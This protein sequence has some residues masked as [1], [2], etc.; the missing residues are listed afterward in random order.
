MHKCSNNFEI[1]TIHFDNTSL[2][3]HVSDNS[4]AVEKVR[5]VDTLTLYFSM[6]EY[7][8][9]PVGAWTFFEGKRYELLDPKNFKKNNTR[10][11]EY[12]LVLEDDAGRLK[13]YKYR[14][15]N[16]R[17]LKFDLT[18][19]P[20]EHIEMLVWNLNQRDPGWTVGVCLDAVEKVVAYNHTSCWDALEQIA[21]AFDTEWEIVDK[22]ISLHK[23]EYYKDNPLPLS[24]GKGNGFKP[25]VGRSNYDKNSPVEILYPQGSDRNINSATYGSTELLLPKNQ[26]LG[27][28]GTT[29]YYNTGSVP[30]GKEVKWY[31]TDADGFSVL[32]K[33]KALTTGAEQSLD[34]SHIYPS[35]VGAISEVI[36]V[37]KDTNLYDFVDSSIPADLD[38]VQY[39]LAGQ[40]LTVIFQEGMLSGKE[41][42]VKYIH[43]DRRFEIVPQDLDGR[44][45]PDEVYKPF[46][47]QKYAVF[48]MMMPE[49]YICNNSSHT[50]AS[51]DMFRECV[52][53]FY[54][55]EDPRFS[56]TGELDSIWAK[57]D[58]EN[59]G[60]RI[61]KGGFIRFSDD[62]FQ[63]EG[64]DIRIVTVTRPANTPRKPKIDLSNVTVSGSIVGELNQIQ[65]NEVLA[66]SGA[67]KA[68][69]YA[70]RRFRDAQ[71]T[72]S[73]L[74]DALLDNFT[75]SINPIAVQTMAMLV[76]DESLQF[77]FVNS[78]TNPV[79]VTHRVVFNASTKQLTVPAGIIQH[80]T[81]GID[82][83]SSTHK[84]EEYRFW[85]LPLFP[86]P[87]L[88]DEKKYYVYA[89]VSR[90]NTTGEF[91]LS[92]T[93]IALESDANYYHL[94]LGILNSA[95]DGIRTDFVP[96]YGFTEILPGQIITDL[97]R[98]GDGKTYFDLARS[99]IGGN[100]KF[101]ATDG[102]S[103]DV[104]N[105]DKETSDFINT[106]FPQTIDDID[107]QIDGKVETWF[108]TT[109]PSRNWSNTDLSKRTGDMWYNAAAKSL[110]RYCKLDIT[111]PDNYFEQHFYSYTPT[112]ANT[113][114]ASWTT[115][116]LKGNHAGDLFYYR[117]T[118][119]VWQWEA[120]DEGVYSWVE[121]EGEKLA[122]AVI[123]GAD[124]I[125]L[126]KTT[127]KVFCATPFPPYEVGNLWIKSDS[128]VSRCI[129]AR[130][131]GS[132][133]ASHWSAL[134]TN[135]REAAL[136]VFAFGWLAIEDQNS[137]DAYD[138]ASQ[139]KDTADGKRRVF[140]TTPVPP[141]DP[142]DLWVDG[143]DLHCCETARKAGQTY[144]ESD[145]KLATKYD[146]TVTTINGG[147]VTSGR[148]QLAGSAGT[149]LAGISGE[150]VDPESI[151]IW[152]GEAY[153]NRTKA[154]FRVQQNGK[155]YMTNAEISG[156]IVVGGSIRS[157]FV[158]FTNSS[159]TW[160]D[161]Y[162]DNM[163]FLA[164]TTSASQSYLIADDVAQAGR[165]ITIVHGM[166]A[167]STPGTYT[168]YS[169]G[170]ATLATVS[171]QTGFY[172]DGYAVKTI[173]ISRQ[174]V[175][176]IGMGDGNVFTG[177]AV[178]G[179]TDIVPTYTYGKGMKAIAYGSVTG[180]SSGASITYQAFD[181]FRTT[182]KITFSVT[183]NGTGNY[184]I[185]FTNIPLASNNYFV[186]LTA[187]GSTLMK[188]TLV[189]KSLSS[190]TVAIS[191][192][193]S[194]ND[195][196]FDFMMMNMDDWNFQS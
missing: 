64:V 71:E 191:D 74:E 190:F 16:T 110:K 130:S 133:L 54:D 5:A 17:R 138:L 111:Q 136:K 63:T 126:G 179:I 147:I 177:W 165:V 108:Q 103:K 38:Y 67:R 78:M 170:T 115:N 100:I 118:N 164:P 88:E 171:G 47:G 157:P 152:A 32:R 20:H 134:T 188:A 112:V 79:A 137:L 175:R 143:T 127:N 85:Q 25:G 24:Y 173:K 187:T 66:D 91:R 26:I 62:Q 102:S 15:S 156:D 104:A 12:T 114:A 116:T 161:P 3:L 95:Y 186:I 172:V 31:K 87:T 158:K 105:L 61:R 6:P 45:M 196:N 162:K 89:K 28:D 19:R 40:T 39:L 8:D 150:G 106:T 33:D 98:S 121:L 96:L 57:K 56:F 49:E 107:E 141:Y 153:A 151:R 9:I 139:A 10:D 155:V 27:Y 2:E 75:N 53:Y 90:T 129:T 4:K 120:D 97:I 44:T 167:G 46:V 77:R 60:G 11:F 160:S 73:M 82:T 154:P 72:I 142:G 168:L 52:R 189:S 148:V 93:A 29:F 36:A 135:V 166:W 18:A 86:S 68:I 131:S 185:S 163:V 69:Q 14:D 35:R 123:L 128:E 1:M 159:G 50:G 181:I 180:T 117:G 169:S 183:R 176:M 146:N 22:R 70:Q 13:R 192:D 76:G 124:S 42:D 48:G 83:I 55:N 30:A 132:Y 92:E 23:V 58:W 178:L 145:W 109:D 84:V 34:C 113:P 140:I 80:M 99:E 149:I 125:S 94:L 122:Q 174:V 7:I 43:A 59:I 41:F 195:G 81:L 184:T 101:L 51:W 21:D 37:N 65:T 144:V 194:A 182:N 119:R 193:S